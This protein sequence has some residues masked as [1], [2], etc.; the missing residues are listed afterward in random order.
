MKILVSAKNGASSFDCDSGEKI[1]HAGL[2][3]GIELPYECG[4]GTCG[5]CKARLV[6]G[7]IDDEWPEAPG[8]RSLRREAREIL[9]CQCVARGDCSLEV[10]SVVEVAPRGACV[11]GG[12]DGVV[13]RRTMLTHDVAALD[14]E[15][16]RPL[17]FDAGQFVLMTVPGV[18]GARAY[19][20]V[21][22]E[23][24]ASRLHFVVK[25][26]PGGGLSAWLFGDAVEGAR[27]RL[28]GPLGFAT[29]RPDLAKNLLCIAGAT[30]I[31]GMLSIL[32]R[33]SQARYFE[34]HTAHVF[35]G[36]RTARDV[37]FLDEL[38]AFKAGYP[39]TLSV[40]VALSDEGVPPSLAAAHPRL[41][42]DAGLVHAVAGRRMKGK[43]ENV[44]AYAA[45]PPPMVEATLRML[46]VEGRLTSDNI[47]YDKFS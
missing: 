31:A 40:T 15:L 32:S 35:F 37:F 47:R 28:F 11:P 4:S 23:R 44:R 33:G 13:R 20:M 24:G 7:R 43:F 14:L 27:V 5:T 17:D 1:L 29:F 39:E 22:F 41:E 26:K 2:R 6:D 16:G 42:F 3:S 34:R 18:V 45:G 46:V 12:V 8:A 21:N 38:A 19:S 9:M 10:A 30:G 36:V 25:N